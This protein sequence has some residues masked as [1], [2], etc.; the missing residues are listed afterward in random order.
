M[1]S[2]LLFKGVSHIWNLHFFFFF[3]NV[4]T[5]LYLSKDKPKVQSSKNTTL[6]LIA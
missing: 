6:T 2:I 5:P 3:K 1:S 4:P